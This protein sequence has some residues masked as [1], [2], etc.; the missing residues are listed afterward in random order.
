MGPREYVLCC[1]AHATPVLPPSCCFIL[2]MAS[3]ERK[4]LGKKTHAPYFLLLIAFFTIA[5]R[6]APSSSPSPPIPMS[7]R[8]TFGGG[9]SS[10]SDLLRPTCK[11]MFKSSLFHS[12]PW[13]LLPASPLISPT[14]VGHVDGEEDAEA[15][16]VMF[17]AHLFVQVKSSLARSLVCHLRW[18]S[19]GGVKT[20]SPPPPLSTVTTLFSAPSGSNAGYKSIWVESGGR[21]AAKACMRDEEMAS[22]FFPPRG[23]ILF[24]ERRP[25]LISLS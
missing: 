22:L 6:L 14:L 10:P 21:S 2:M 15:K 9:A 19:R 11:E 24:L 16:P 20:K 25:L 23:T 17:A 8:E 7:H 18:E 1:A 12:S 13:G 4:L 3:Y 5:S